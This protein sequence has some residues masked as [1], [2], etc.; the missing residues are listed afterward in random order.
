MSDEIKLHG[1]IPFLK[2]GL[3]LYLNNFF[4]LIILSIITT[5]PS[6]L[7]ATVL[8]ESME[9]LIN[10]S[11]A[12]AST[13]ILVQLLLS[14]ALSVFTTGLMIMIISRS[15][16]GVEKISVKRYVHVILPRILPMLAVSFIIGFFTLVGLFLVILPGLMAITG[17]SLATS[18]M[19]W[20]NR[21]MYDSLKRS[22]DITSGERLNIFLYIFATAII[23]GA[24]I[25]GL[26][27]FFRWLI[28]LIF[29]VSDPGIMT[30]MQYLLSAIVTPFS[31][32]VL[33]LL[34]FNI[35]VDKEEYSKEKLESWFTSNQ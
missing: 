28:Q 24:V 29:N 33:V 21:G 35:L 22:W 12:F 30:H 7:Y 26:I 17:F 32:A 16:A 13:M 5:L 23:N 1:L 19:V 14:F 10:S 15:L 25:I 6:Y 2:R 8:R 27:V 20:E 11:Q 4:P 3:K 31:H 34:Y 9:G 18:I